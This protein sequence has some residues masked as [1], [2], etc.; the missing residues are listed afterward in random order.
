MQ[1]INGLPV[2]DEDRVKLTAHTWLFPNM[3]KIDALL[4]WISWITKAASCNHKK[5][6]GS[7]AMAAAHNWLEKYPMPYQPGG[8][9]ALIN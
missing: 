1:N 8:T 2:D 5:M 6:V 3:N 4:V 7:S 9:V